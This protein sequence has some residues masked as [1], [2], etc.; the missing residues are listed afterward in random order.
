MASWKDPDQGKC[1]GAVF[2]G[3]WFSGVQLVWAHVCCLWVPIVAL[4]LG[5]VYVQ[6]LCLPHIICLFSVIANHF[7]INWR[8]MEKLWLVRAAII[9]ARCYH[10]NLQSKN[11]FIQVL[12]FKRLLR[13]AHIYVH[14]GTHV[15]SHVHLIS[16]HQV[17]L[18]PRNIL[19]PEIVELSS[20]LW[21]LHVVRNRIIKAKVIT[22]A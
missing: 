15:F 10:K 2:D 11:W 17:L 22:F 14:G 16:S 19:A 8:R 9:S 1:R 3:A 12:T 21:S 7:I 20:W 4:Q 6:S 18:C 13:D 5:Q